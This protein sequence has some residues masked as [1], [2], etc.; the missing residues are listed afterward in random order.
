M[1]THGTSTK[2]THGDDGQDHT[3]EVV[4]LHAKDRSPCPLTG[5]HEHRHHQGRPLNAE[6][7]ALGG[8]QGFG[9]VCSCGTVID[10]GSKLAAIEDKARHRALHRGDLLV[11]RVVHDSDGPRVIHEIQ[12]LDR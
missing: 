11:H 1:N 8:R 7:A 6:C 5:D 10:S 4:A 12:T 2:D 3:S 9:V